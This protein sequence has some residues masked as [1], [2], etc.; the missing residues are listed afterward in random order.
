MRRPVLSSKPLP[1]E[2]EPFKFAPEPAPTDARHETRAAFGEHPSDCQ[3]SA[4]H[5]AGGVARKYFS[6]TLTLGTF[7]ESCFSGAFTSRPCS[8]P[9]FGLFEVLITIALQVRPLGS[10][11][12]ISLHRSMLQRRTCHVLE[13]LAFLFWLNELL[14]FF[15]LRTPLIATTE[16]ALNANLAI[17]SFNITLGGILAFLLTVCYFW[18]RNSCVLCWKQ[19]SLFA[20]LLG[21]TR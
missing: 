20:S 5:F 21:R 3:K 19:T 15:G 14:S 6:D 16:A 9:P 1:P 4:H 17:G 10:L 18:S 2:A 12:V 11:R 7:W 13:F 8:I